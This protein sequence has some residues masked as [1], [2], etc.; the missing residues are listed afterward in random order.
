MLKVINGGKEPTRGSKYSACIDLYANEDCII[1]AGETVLVGLGV[2]IDLSL[3]KLKVCDDYPRT[4]NGTDS[5]MFDEFMKSH[6]LNLHIRSSMSAKHGLIIANGTGI[7][8]LDFISHCKIDKMNNNGKCKHFKQKIKG[9]IAMENNKCEECIHWDDCEIK[10]CLHN[11]IDENYIDDVL[12]KNKNSQ[13]YGQ[14]VIKKGQPIAQLS[15]VEHK[16]YLFDVES[17][18]KRTGGFGSTDA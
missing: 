9:D 10:I 11:P 18:D 15:L 1:G 14:V 4:W 5:R 3:I 16:S 8:D 17:E 7:I 2:V 12:A 6:Q 13:Y